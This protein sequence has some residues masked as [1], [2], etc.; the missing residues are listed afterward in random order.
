MFFT[1]VDTNSG[2]SYLIWFK[3]FK[4]IKNILTKP[5][6]ETLSKMWYDPKY[7][8]K[9]STSKKYSDKPQKYRAIST[10][11]FSETFK[12]AWI[13]HKETQG[14]LFVLFAIFFCLM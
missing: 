13:A 8:T 4:S 5:A 7:N 2:V 3:P 10:E 9:H 6:Y 14:V 12:N 1:L 11:Y